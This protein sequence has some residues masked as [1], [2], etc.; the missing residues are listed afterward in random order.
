MNVGVGGEVGL[1]A[2]LGVKFGKT[3][4]VK[5]PLVTVKAECG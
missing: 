5:L 3:T 2:E 4:E 1:K